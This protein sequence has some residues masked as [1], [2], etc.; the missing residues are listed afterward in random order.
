MMHLVHKVPDS[1]YSA[2]VKY[3]SPPISLI[4]IFLVSPTNERFATSPF[5]DSRIASITLASID[6]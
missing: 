4:A 1:N 5:A 2:S 6:I 3:P